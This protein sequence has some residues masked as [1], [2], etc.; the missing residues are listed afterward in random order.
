MIVQTNK[1]IVYLFFEIDYFTSESFVK[2]LI[3]HLKLNTTYSMLVKFSDEENTTFK[4]SGRQIG[5]VIKDSHDIN[6]YAHLYDTCIQRVQSTAQNY[7]IMNSIGLIEIS[8]IEVKR[9]NEYILQNVEYLKLKKGLINVS[10]T[11]T[12]F[13]NNLLPLTLDVKFYGDRITNEKD[14][15]H[16]ISIINSAGNP[17]I[18][19]DMQDDIFI[20]RSKIDSIIIN[21]QDSFQKYVFNLNTGILIKEVTDTII[22][23]FPELVWSRKIDGTLLYIKN[24]KVLTV[25]T[26]FSVPPINT[27]DLENTRK[28][29]KLAL[30][31]LDFGSFDVE[32]FLDSDG[33]SKVY[34][35]GFITQKDDK[36]KMFYLTDYE[37][38]NEKIKGS[39]YISSEELIIKCIDAMLIT[40][41]NNFKFYTHNL[42]RYDVVF[43]YNALLKINN[44]LGYEHYKLSTIMREDVIIKLTVKIKKE[45]NSEYSR[46]IKIHFIDSLNLL[47]SSLD[48]LAKDFN[49]ETGKGQFPYTFVNRSSLNYLGI[50][51]NISFY[52]NISIEDYNRIPHENWDL[53]KES[54]KYLERDLLSLLQIIDEFSRLTYIYYNTDITKA[55]TITRLALN[56]FL[57]KYYSRV[58]NDK[59]YSNNK[60]PLINKQHI[61]N[62]IKDGYYGGVTEVYKPYG[63]DLVYLDINSLY[64]HASLNDLPGQNIEFLESFEDKGLDLNNLFGFFYAR[65][66]TNNTEKQNYLGLLPLHR[67]HQMILP[68]GVFYGTWSSEELKFARDCAW[69]V[70]VIRGLN[71]NKIDSVFKEYVKDL[72][73]MKSK[74]VGAK[75]QIAKSL[76]N[77]LIGRFGL[78]IVKPI[79]RILKEKDKDLI[80]STRQV[81][82]IKP[83]NYDSYLVT[84][85]PRLDKTVCAEYEMDY[86]K[87]LSRGDSLEKSSKVFSEVSIST[88]A[89]INSYARIYMNKM[90][91]FVLSEGGEIFYS[92]TD[93]LIVSKDII[94]LMLE[95]GY[96]GPNIGQFKIE[97]DI[98]EGYFVSNKT[99]CLVTNDN[100]TIIKAKGANPGQLTLTDFKNLYLKNEDVKATKNN[101]KIMYD[102]G[103]VIINKI[104]ISLKH[105]SYAKRTKLYN[106]ENVWIDTKPLVLN[107]S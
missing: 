65:I 50:K 103:T 7:E 96:I 107:E 80:S 43:M 79:T 10:K 98:R 67:N 33:I 44:S 59:T 9:E 31:D 49:V 48:K 91:L 84:Y 52:N 102:K 42:G 74:E 34:A 97:H 41:Y 101:T 87:L 60:L 6:F 24:S 86:M 1:N 73:D 15:T 38:T 63:K 62:F 55:L 57:A 27:K 37:T 3:N 28:S 20:Y 95:K 2:A 88:P 94:P 85:T 17:N 11:K 25:K 39:N 83:L 45:A 51:P 72:Y 53:R 14:K 26:Q 90:K 13:N 16:Y 75:K 105:D 78:N 99:Y 22:A 58:E 106:K 19:I 56:V 36:V 18:N 93:S 40:R 12:D 89:M 5:I 70:K 35:L 54:L 81:L 47:N 82:G 66:S 68:H 23:R 4:M 92:D 76:L 32:T 46:F 64:P 61:F 21:K 69:D 30:R 71:F 100:K 29:T 8:L 104:D 77:N